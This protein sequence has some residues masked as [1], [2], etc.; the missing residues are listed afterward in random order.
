MGASES[1]A[2]RAF[3]KSQLA[4]YGS[5]IFIEKVIRPDKNG[6]P[7]IYGVFKGMPFFLEAKAINPISF[8]NS[9]PFKELQIATL[10][11]REK[12]GATCLGL[13]CLKND[14]RYLYP[15]E[16]KPF[17][18]KSDWETAR[19]FSWETLRLNWLERL[20]SF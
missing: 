10:K 3:V 19:K 11:D 7:D 9:H 12:A 14:V 16:I 15:S 4:I 13:L 20:T 2:S 5:S 1:S 18:E 6:E 17:L 8:K